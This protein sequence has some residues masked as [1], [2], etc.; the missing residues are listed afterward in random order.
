MSFF[1]TL[2]Q[3]SDW[4][5][6]VLR[7]GVGVTFLVHG[8]L[9]WP[10]WKAQ[11][12]PQLPASLLSILRLLSIAE[13]LGGVAVLVGFLTQAAAAGFAIIML[14]AIRLKAA[15]MHKAFSG[16]GGWEFDFILLA[17]AI[18]LFILGAGGLSLDHV[19]FGL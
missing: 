11:P 1:A 14:G 9:K 5:L 2:H 17:A 7:V 15:Q 4:A 6:L 12:S 13:P 16:D 8:V 18:A 10:M 19:L 3:G